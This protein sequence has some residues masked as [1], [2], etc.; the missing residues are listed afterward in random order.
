MA[1]ESLLKAL[2]AAAT[3]P[4]ALVAYAF[5]A[6]AW[7]IVAWRT[8]RNKQLLAHLAKVPEKDRARLIRDEMGVV[9]LRE[10]LSAEQW[11]RSRIS[12]YYLIGFL[13]A[14]VAAA[15]VLVVA[16]AAP[17]P[18]ADTKESTNEDAPENRWHFADVGAQRSFVEAHL[19]PP[20]NEQ[21]G[22][23]L[24]RANYRT[25]LFYLQ[26]T[27]DSDGRVVQSA[28]TSRQ[29][30][31]H[32]RVPFWPYG[33]LVLGKFSFSALEDKT[34]PAYFD[35]SSKDWYYVEALGG[36]GA[37]DGKS[38]YIGYSDYGAK[39]CHTVA[40][41]EGLTDVL[42]AAVSDFSALGEEQKR[43]WRTYREGECPNAFAIRAPLDHDEIEGDD[44]LLLPVLD[45][46]VVYEIGEV[47]T[48]ES[49][50]TAA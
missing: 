20:R 40:G 10:G 50:D 5:A 46:E 27:Y 36:F 33:E 37:T 17:Q 19:G 35:F 48:Q 38:V 6:A 47:A 18:Q 28:V 23:K 15:V 43:S 13:V 31:F 25:E 39:Y 29:A 7:A 11:L 24:V 9:R 16:L 2:P 34:S 49:P 21:R 12:L 14:C 32:P 45:R 4:Y 8:Q 44:H 3:G 26:V 30:S 42:F 41:Q 22:L 1:I